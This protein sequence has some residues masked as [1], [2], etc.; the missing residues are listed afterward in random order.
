MLPEEQ[1]I[2]PQNKRTVENK[3]RLGQ[4][5]AGIRHEKTQLLMA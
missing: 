2:A 5:S 3:P 1:K 4:G